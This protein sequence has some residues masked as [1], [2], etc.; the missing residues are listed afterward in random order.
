M[1]LFKNIKD[2]LNTHGKEL[3]DTKDVYLGLV[4]K[5]NSLSISL[6][7]G[8][9]KLYEQRKESYKKLMLLDSYVSRL[10][11]CP[12]FL[13]QG[14]KRAL[15][16]AGQIKEAWDF[17]NSPHDVGSTGG[18]AANAAIVGT[19][20]VGGTI[21]TAGT[22]AA[23][24]IATTFGTASTGAAISSLGGAAAANAA[25]AWLGGGAMAAGGAG[26]A[27]GA[28]FLAAIPWIGWGIA[29]TAGVA[30]ILK[31]RFDA[32]KNLEK[33]KELDSFIKDE[34]K[35]VNALTAMN[36][37][38]QQIISFTVSENR[39]IDIS[40]F[41]SAPKCFSDPKYP[42]LKLVDMV[43]KAKQIGKVSQESITM[44]AHD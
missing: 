27:G 23:M 5:R 26:I 19:A 28:A 3:E 36:D 8:A 17:E 11:E 21:A 35:L 31:S 15:S 22:T 4:D 38:L 39:K 41:T 9:M 18:N 42:Q 14:T 12:L 10:E 25:L 2:K 24:A 30:M 16:Y 32:K 7:E 44:N 20:V 13:S 33:I 29:G 1:G 40:L 37:R 34:R 43:E 6:Q